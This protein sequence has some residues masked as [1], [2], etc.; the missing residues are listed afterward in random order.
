MRALLRSFLDR[1][2]TRGALEVASATG[3]AF[4]VGNGTG[5]PVAVEF[6]DQ[7]AERRLLLDPALALGELYVEG[8]L[9]VTRGSIY[10]LLTLIASNLSWE[11]PPGF[12]RARERVRRTLRPLHQRNSKRRAERNVAHLQSR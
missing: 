3:P 6:S 2:V 8:R 11:V 10:D 5:E 12:A 1:V 4:I 9:A 7:A